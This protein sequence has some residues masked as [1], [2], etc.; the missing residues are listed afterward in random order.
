MFLVNSLTVDVL[1]VRW[2]LLA[3]AVG[4][5]TGKFV[6]NGLNVLQR[7]EHLIKKCYILGL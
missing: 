3:A 7:E 2:C 6:K 5:R 1:H 4:P